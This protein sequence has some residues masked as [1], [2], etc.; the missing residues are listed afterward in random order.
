MA[1]RDLPQEK[2]GSGTGRQVILKGDF[3]VIETAVLEV[4]QVLNPPDLVWVSASQVKVPATAECKARVLM[5]GFPSPWGGGQWV[6]G[7]LSDGRYREATGEVILDLGLAAHRWG[8]EKPSQWYA[9]YAVAGNTDASFTLKAMPVLRVAA[10]AAQTITLR[11]NANDANLGYGFATDELQ[12]F[13]LLVL[14]GAATGRCRP[15]TANNNDDGSNGT[16]SYGGTTL[17]LAAGDWFV[18]LPATN[19][20]YLGMIYNNAAGNLEP[21]WQQGRRWEWRSKRAVPI[22]PTSGWTALDLS[23]LVPPTARSFLGLAGAQ[24][25]YD[26]KAAFSADGATTAMQVHVAPPGTPFQGSRGAVPC[27]CRVLDGSWVYYNN[28]NTANQLLW[29]VGWEEG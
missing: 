29:A 5:A 21:F 20:R 1:L 3:A 10:Q 28:E 8:T 6:A 25:G 11:N 9:V 23:L 13:Q 12:N 17:T 26:V 19:F 18:L 2:W 27:R 14:S 4:F 22:Q 7:G 15:V 24:A 16:I